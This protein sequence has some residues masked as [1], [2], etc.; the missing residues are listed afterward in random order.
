MRISK[1]LSAVCAA[2]FFA[3][4]LAVRAQDT[5]AQAAARA[6]LMQKM[7]DLDTQQNQPTNATPA[8]PPVTP[9][10]AET[11]PA[12]AVTA[13]PESTPTPAVAVAPV[14]TPEPAA[15]P[16]QPADNS[17]LFTPVPPPS[18]PD[19]Q[20]GVQAA[21]QQQLSETNQQPAAMPPP[22]PI[23]VTASGVEQPQAVPPTNAAPVPSADKSG[24]SRPAPKVAA[25][26]P[27]KPVASGA[28]PVVNPPPVNMSYAGKSL[29]LQQITAPPPPVSA[30][31][32]AALQALLARYMADQI[33]PEEY[34]KERA[35][36][37]AGP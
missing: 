18:N 35:A 6:M 3:G 12:P 16:V 25:A 27:A 30:Q 29:G 20:A 5:P 9:A 14:Q 32:E 2:A 19:A 26:H 36:I 24:A 17:G 15:T 7:S 21:L 22:P 10:P 37:L 23:V 28:A 34:Q 31:K 4:I 13:V 11:Q 33:T 8:P 1:L